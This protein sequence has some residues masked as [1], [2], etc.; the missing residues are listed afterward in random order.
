MKRISPCLAT[1]LAWAM[2]SVMLSMVLAA[3]VAAQTASATMPAHGRLAI[4]PD[5]PTDIVTTAPDAITIC[6]RGKRNERYRLPLRGETQADGPT[7]VAGE[8][9]S[10]R[11]D[12]ANNAPCGIF[13]GQR[14]CGKREARAFGYGGGRDPLS[15][16]TRL[17][18]LLLDPDAD[19]AGSLP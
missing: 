1:L 5:C 13:E 11:L 18:T 12:P 3:P 6:G 7:R 15:V 9:P 14:R 17:G 19:V 2:V 16:M 8:I 4:Q 10:A